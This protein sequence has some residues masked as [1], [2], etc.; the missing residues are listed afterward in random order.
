M[1]VRIPMVCSGFPEQPVELDLQQAG[2]RIV[3]D[4][5]QLARID[6]LHF[7]GG[8][9]EQFLGTITVTTALLINLNGCRNNH[10]FI[11]SYGANIR[12]GDGSQ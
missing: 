7:H 4:G 12:A 2:A 9:P 11:V 8:I 6:F 3:S 10:H 5:A 1:A